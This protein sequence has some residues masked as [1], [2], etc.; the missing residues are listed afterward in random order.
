MPSSPEN[1]GFQGNWYTFSTHISRSL[2]YTANKVKLTSKMRDVFF[3][4]V[5]EIPL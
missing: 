4:E 1:T 5:W 2:W 3:E